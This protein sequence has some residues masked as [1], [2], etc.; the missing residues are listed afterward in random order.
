MVNISSSQI[1][2]QGREDGDSCSGDSGGPLMSDVMADSDDPYILLG[3]VSFGPRRCG[4]ANFPSVYARVSTY[5]EWITN[6]M[7]N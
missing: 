2:V 4:I 5:M 3:L 6:N 1:C 7:E